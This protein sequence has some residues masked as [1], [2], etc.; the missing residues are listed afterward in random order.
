MS[1]PYIVDRALPQRSRLIFY[2]P[3]KE[4]RTYKILMP[5]FENPSIKERKKA[6]YKKHSLISRS[7]NLYT[8]HGADSR[9][10]NLSFQF[11]I[12]HLLEEQSQLLI[13]SFLPTGSF[14]TFN[15]EKTI[16]Y[17]GKSELETMKSDEE[18]NYI[19]DLAEKYRNLDSVKYSAKR[20]IKGVFGNDPLQPID[21]DE[22]NLDS[23]DV[24]K[25]TFQ[26]GVFPNGNTKR[27]TKKIIHYRQ[28][29]FGLILL[30]QV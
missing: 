29:C 13:N 9:E 24:T 18:N 19:L 6:R 20:N 8:Y 14:E 7:S 26:E 11:T 27:T 12:P 28:L 4:D 1:N 30:E 3:K 23:V 17:L 2:F 16:N 25:T 15:F 10:L 22:I 5:F 21:L